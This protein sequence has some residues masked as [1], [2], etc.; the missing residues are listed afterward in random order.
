MTIFLYAAWC[1]VWNYIRGRGYSDKKWLF[2]LSKPFC[3]AYMA[4]P[5]TFFVN[6]YAVA[7]VWI[8]LMIP[9]FIGW[10]KAMQA[11]RGQG[12]INI[13][14]NEPECLPID[15]IVNKI[16]GEA[17]TKQE[18]RE[19][20]ALWGNIFGATYYPMF[21]YL[22]TVQDLRYFAALLPL[23]M[24]GFIISFFRE[25]RWF[26]LTWGCVLG[27]LIGAFL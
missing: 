10:G 25:W 16:Y 19:K 22:G 21:I 2:F 27:G 8:G 6:W 1:G 12:N 3:Y 7:A 23:I 15:Y 13:V 11:M 18:A 9:S 4:L 14:N 26:E 24:M 20:A 5:M 17:K